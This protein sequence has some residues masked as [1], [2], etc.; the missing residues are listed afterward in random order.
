MFPVSSKLAAERASIGKQTGL[1]TKIRK[2]L[3]LKLLIIHFPDR[4][5]FDMCL[6]KRVKQF[7]IKLNFLSQVHLKFLIIYFPPSRHVFI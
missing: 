4:F 5:Y 3:C 7:K 2:F 1:L 6:L